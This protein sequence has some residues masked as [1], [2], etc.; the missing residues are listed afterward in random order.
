VHLG[1]SKPQIGFVPAERRC[2]VVEAVIVSCQ[3]VGVQHTVVSAAIAEVG[4]EVDVVTEVGAG[5]EAGAEVEAGAGV[6]A[7]AGA[8]AEAGVGVEAGAGVGVDAGAGGV[9]VKGSV[10]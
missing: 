8:E 7:D 2:T 4:A 10:G 3:G 5:V 6:E 9:L 1:G